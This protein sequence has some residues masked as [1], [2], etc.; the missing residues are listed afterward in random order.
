MICSQLAPSFI[1]LCAPE[2]ITLTSWFFLLALI[3]IW[4]SWTGGKGLTVGGFPNPSLSS[5]R[6]S[7]L[8]PPPP[9]LLEW[10]SCVPCS[11]FSSLIPAIDHHVWEVSQ[12]WGEWSF[13]PKHFPF[14]PSSGDSSKK[15]SSKKP[16]F[17]Q[18]DWSIRLW[19]VKSLWNLLLLSSKQALLQSPFWSS[20]PTLF[21]PDSY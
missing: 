8:P 10:V 2:R 20:V 3:F 21:W 6:S 17:H 11:C 18:D 9:A 19:P 1:V 15:R 4:S 7:L 13:S 16:E 5:S 14:L 12:Q